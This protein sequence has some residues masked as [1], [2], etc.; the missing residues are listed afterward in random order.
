MSVLTLVR[1]GQASL[2]AAD[3]D[4][5][6]KVG[7]QQACALGAYWAKHGTAIDAVYC[8]PRVRHRRFM[9]LVGETYAGQGRNW[10]EPVHISELDEFD[11]EGFTTQLIPTLTGRD[12]DFARLQREFF[13]CAIDSERDRHFQNL[14]EFVMRHWQS[15]D[16]LEADIETW[17]A[18]RERVTGVMAQIRRDAA[19][20]SRTVVFTSGGVIGCTLQQALG[21]SDAMMRELSWRIRNASLTEFV[22]T[23]DRFTLDAFNLVPHLTRSEL[24]TYR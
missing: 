19:R 18:F 23:P 4:R 5:L 10:P 17:G 1:H 22:F 7:E 20:S 8:G 24:L 16:T 2:F 3:Y 14:F 12:S 11:L 6:S 13:E 21:V 15:A 9:E